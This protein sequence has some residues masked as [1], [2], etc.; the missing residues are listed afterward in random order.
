MFG[1]DL[2]GFFLFFSKTG[3]RS[4]VFQV[5]VELGRGECNWVELEERWETEK[6]RREQRKESKTSTKG[7]DI[8]PVTPHSI[9]AGLRADYGT[10]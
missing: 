1:V 8:V 7:F 2:K 9:S 6:V 4:P 5:V 10:G 3:Q